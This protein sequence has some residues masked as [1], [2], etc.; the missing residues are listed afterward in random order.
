MMYMHQDVSFGPC[1][2]TA[3][4][5]AARGISRV[6]DEALS[7]RGLTSAQFAILRHIARS[8]PVALSRLAEQL[9]MERT[10][11]YRALTPLEAKGWV[12]VGSGPGKSRLASLTAAGRTAMDDAELAW[13][14]VQARI[15]TAMGPQ[16]WTELQ[17]AL[18]TVISFA[19]QGAG[20]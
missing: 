10:S 2:C 16:Q 9:V 18:N 3:L 5:K 12:T 4:R 20:R 19:E 1:A 13:A 15:V 8:E 7:S 6:Y 17:S 11:L 14:D